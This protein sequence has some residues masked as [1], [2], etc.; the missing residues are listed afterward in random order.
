MFIDPIPLKKYTP[1]LLNQAPLASRLPWNRRAVVGHRVPAPWHWLAKKL[2]GTSIFAPLYEINPDYTILY[3]TP[4]FHCF[5]YHIIVA[6]SCY[7]VSHAN[8]DR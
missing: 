6:I 1:A 4:F 3:Y 2:K 7:C 8:I 5:Q